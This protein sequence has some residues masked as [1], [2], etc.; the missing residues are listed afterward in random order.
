MISAELTT[1]Y[2]AHHRG[3]WGMAYRMLGDAAEAEDVVHD[4]F[5]KALS[6]PPS[7]TE[8]LRPW[9]ITVALNLARDR[10]RARRRLRYPGPWLPTPVGDDA[11][12]QVPLSHN[13]PEA[14]YALMESATLAFL[15]AL[16]ALTPQQR[17]VLILRDVY[18][19][20]GPEA[21]ARLEMSPGNVKVVLHRARKA[22]ATY[23]RHRCDPATLP[24]QTQLALGQMMAALAAGDLD[25]LMGLLSTDVLSLSDGG[26]V[27]S[28]A[29][30]P[31]IGARPV[32][33]MYL[34]LAQKRPVVTVDVV[35]VNGLPA[36]DLRFAPAKRQAPRS[37]LVVQP[38]GTGRIVGVYS[39]LAPTKLP[40]SG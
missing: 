10:L 21:A 30:R 6:R 36:L 5:A 19:F 25:G 33:R 9:L 17:A 14:R 26:G 40:S 29:M 1:L 20:T 15:T 32:A 22:L 13:Q 31:V 18:G 37:L 39:L 38:D 16:E 4:T 11:A 27:F 35:Q 24:E 12:L 3:L 8:P 7:T 34:G 2:E 28:A 23:D